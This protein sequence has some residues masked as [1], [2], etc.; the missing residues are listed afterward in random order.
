VDA[1]DRARFN[2]SGDPWR[3]APTSELGDQVLP[4]WFVLTALVTALVAIVVLVS[5]FLLPSRTTVPVVARR[6]PASAAY[7]TAAGEVSS[8]TSAARPYTASCAALQGVR[9]A[10][11]DADRAQL[12][13]GL[14]GLCNV[15][16]PMPVAQ[17]L[18]AFADD[19][20]VV[21][22]ATFA[23]TGVDATATRRTDADTQPTILVNARFGRTDPLWIAPLVVYHATLRRL[24]PTRAEAALAAR[25]AEAQVCARTLGTRPPSR[26]CADAEAITQLED[27]LGALRAVGFK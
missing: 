21:R 27:P 20:G 1:H 14:A 19:G 15:E 23:A 12:R 13:R 5:A 25:R 3:D 10:G 6:P 18:A 17:D 4:R 11:S 8:G 9:L 24:D 26:G 7:T 22:F 2:G 16:L